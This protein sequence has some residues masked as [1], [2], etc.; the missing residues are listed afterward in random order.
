MDK[1]RTKCKHCGAW[2][3]PA[4]GA[5]GPHEHQEAQGTKRDPKAPGDYDNICAECNYGRGLGGRED[6]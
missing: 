1:Q 4:F 2:I 6:R 3:N 5:D